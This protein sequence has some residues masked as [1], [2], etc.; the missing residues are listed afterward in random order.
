ML[1][2]IDFLTLKFT[3]EFIPGSNLAINQ[4]ITLGPSKE[5]KTPNNSETFFA[6]I[7]FD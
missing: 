2:Q 1:R 5:V 6:G 4:G 3:L 7:F